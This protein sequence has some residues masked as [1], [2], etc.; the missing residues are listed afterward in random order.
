MTRVTSAVVR[1]TS[2]LDILQNKETNGVILM[3]PDICPLVKAMTCAAPFG[4]LAWQESSGKGR[5]R[6]AVYSVLGSCCV[7]P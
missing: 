3:M 7:H 6:N 5:E 4:L 2:M 1:Y